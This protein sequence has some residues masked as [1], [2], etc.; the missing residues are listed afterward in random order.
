LTGLARFHRITPKRAIL[1]SFLKP[2]NFGTKKF[3]IVTDGLAHFHRKGNSMVFFETCQFWHEKRIAPKKG[4][5]YA[6]AQKG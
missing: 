5:F 4:R 3:K 1:W 2:V 6:L